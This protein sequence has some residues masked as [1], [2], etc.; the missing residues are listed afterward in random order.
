M[1][2]FWAVYCLPKSTP[3][4]QTYHFPLY[5][6]LWYHGGKH[7]DS[8]F[9]TKLERTDRLQVFQHGCCEHFTLSPVW[10]VLTGTDYQPWWLSA[11]APGPSMT[12][13]KRNSPGRI[14]TLNLSPFWWHSSEV[15][16]PFPPTIPQRAWVTFSAAHPLVASLYPLL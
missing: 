15:G 14:T 7:S 3:P 9:Y 5:S 12:V 1:A 16:W 10:D 11:L 13:R 2:V 6:V 4:Q 8:L